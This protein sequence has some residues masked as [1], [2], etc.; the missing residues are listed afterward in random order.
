MTRVLVPLAI[1]EGESVSAGLTT[2]LAPLDV[3]VLGYHVLPEQTPPDQARLQYEERA[4]DALVDLTAEFEAAGG[5]A[6]HRLVFTHD[7]EQT[8]DRVAAET[9]ADAYAI[10]GVTGPIDRLLVS[11]TGDVAVDR[12]C[13]FAAE[14]VGDR[15]IGVTLFLA[16]DDE[17]GGR[18]SLEAAARSLSERGID[19]ET[20]LAGDQPAL[21]ALVEAAIGHDA[22]V[23][24]ERAPSLRSLVFGE[25][26]E[27][28]AA[29]SVGPVLVVRRVE[30]R[31]DTVERRD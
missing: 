3:T 1:L 28:V 30:E 19:V 2:L 21:E 23:M 5:R 10:T 11:L 14:L 6:D 18:E 26:A 22:I 20:E 31:D 7:R 17:S 25:E 12:L 4:T 24:G 8:I 13:S 29:E 15:E 27:Q 9:G 16:T